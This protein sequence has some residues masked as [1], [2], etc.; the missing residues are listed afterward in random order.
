MDAALPLAHAAG[1]ILIN[2][3][4][5]S[6]FANMNSSGGRRLKKGGRS[7]SSTGMTPQNKSDLR[8]RPPAYNVPASVPRSVANQIVYDVVRFNST[9]T[10]STSAITETNTGFYLNQHPQ[11]GSWTTLFDQWCV[12]QASVTW[13]SKQ[14]PGDSNTTP[15]MYTALD[16]DNTANLGTIAAIEDFSTC[17]VWRCNPDEPSHTRSIKPCTKSTQSGT[18]NSG[19]SRSWVDCASSSIPFYGIRSIVDVGSGVQTITMVITVWF[20]FRN[21]I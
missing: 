16:F 6:M 5:E 9:I 13:Y 15:V 4:L 12:P 1:G 18:A 20:A 7:T 14:A 8:V 19:L 10:T 11:A 17:A 21:Q 3:L 2:K